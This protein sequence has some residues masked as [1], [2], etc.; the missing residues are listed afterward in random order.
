MNQFVLI[1]SEHKFNWINLAL[2]IGWNR[3]FAKGFTSGVSERFNDL[4][5]YRRK[6]L[7][8][9]ND[10]YRRELV[11]I[12]SYGS[13]VLDVYSGESKYNADEQNI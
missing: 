12:L 10:R 4:S 13:A 11:V 7:R 1:F 3:Q 8:R 5:I 9:G 2:L 6:R